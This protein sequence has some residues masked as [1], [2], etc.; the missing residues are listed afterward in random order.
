M[1]TK[2]YFMSG[3]DAVLLRYAE[4][5]GKD[6]PVKAAPPTRPPVKRSVLSLLL[7][8]ALLTLTIRRAAPGASTSKAKAPATKRIAAVKVGNAKAS[9]SKAPA[10]ARAAPAKTGVKSIETIRSFA[11]GGGGGGGSGSGSGIKAM[12]IRKK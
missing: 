4:E 2:W 12:P 1:S 9:T 11:F 6:V 8:R 10:K 7:R 3:A 5:A